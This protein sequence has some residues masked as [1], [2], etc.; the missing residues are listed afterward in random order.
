M[1]LIRITDPG[2]KATRNEQIHVSVEAMRITDPG[3]KA[4]SN[5]EAIRRAAEK[6]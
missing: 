5:R 6:E 4:T 3:L 2:L 1:A